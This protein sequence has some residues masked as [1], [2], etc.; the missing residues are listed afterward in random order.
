ME[1]LVV[2]GAVADEVQLLQARPF[3]VARP[4]AFARSLLPWASRRTSSN[5]V[6]SGCR[7]LT[8]V[9]SSRSRAFRATTSTMPTSSI[10]PADARMFHS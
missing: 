5:Q 2:C 10:T 6:L 8:Q 4:L 3:R 1:G 9:V 7:L